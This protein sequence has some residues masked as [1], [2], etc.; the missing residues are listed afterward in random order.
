M[1]LNH[2]GHNSISH[3][4]NEFM[5]ELDMTYWPSVSV[6][7]FLVN[8]STIKEAKDGILA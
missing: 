5:K 4:V 8:R 7:F 2:S 6:F 3:N 1:L